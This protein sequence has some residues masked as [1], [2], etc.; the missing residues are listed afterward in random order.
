MKGGCIRRLNGFRI[1]FLFIASGLRDS[2]SQELF[3]RGQ[4]TS[5]S[6]NLNTSL[7]AQ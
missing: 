3:C 6:F 1:I 4:H 2:E 7:N 5:V